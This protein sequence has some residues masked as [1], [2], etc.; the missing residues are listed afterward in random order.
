LAERLW[1]KVNG[2]WYGNAPG[3]DDCW[4][5]MGRSAIGQ[6]IVNHNGRRVRNKHKF[7]YGRIRS[8]GVGTPIIGAHIAAYIVTYG[9]VPPGKYICHHCDNHL[10]CNP[11]HLYAG[12]P[13]E[14]ARDTTIRGRRVTSAH[15][16]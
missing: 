16:A 12:T 7:S 5:W 14:N 3:D 4:E 8:G 9:P 11:S 6:Y 1:I 13:L 15:A 10:C 2:P